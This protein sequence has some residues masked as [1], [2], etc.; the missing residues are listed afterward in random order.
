MGFQIGRF[1]EHRLRQPGW[2]DRAAPGSVV[3]SFNPGTEFIPEREC[4]YAFAA[5]SRN[6]A[7]CSGPKNRPGQ[8][9]TAQLLFHLAMPAW[10]R[11]SV[12]GRTHRRIQHHVFHAPSDASVNHVPFESRQLR[13]RRA[14]QIYAFHSAER[15]AKCVGFREVCNHRLRTRWR[16]P[17]RY[18][19][20]SGR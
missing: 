3:R 15:G 8:T 12:I 13:N 6:A 5:C 14:H 10:E 7:A 9:R 4:R 18:G 1:F 19:A 20:S 16:L 2:A 17:G 11:L